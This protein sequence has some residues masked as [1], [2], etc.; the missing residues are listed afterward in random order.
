[1]T[2][3]PKGKMHELSRP[4]PYSKHWMYCTGSYAGLLNEEALCT[5]Q[6]SSPACTELESLVMDWLG[7][8]IGLPAEFLHR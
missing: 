7:Q 8:M 6:A 4:V 1:M 3:P 2:L 5:T